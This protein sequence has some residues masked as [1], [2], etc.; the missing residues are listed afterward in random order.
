MPI[1]RP[2]RALRS[3]IAAPL[4]VAAGAVLG[5]AVLTASPAAADSPARERWPDGGQVHA[6][7]MYDG[8][9][10]QE[11]GCS[12][13]A[14]TVSQTSRD[15]MTFQLRWSSSCQ[16]NWVRILRYPGNI[17]AS[18]RDGLWMDVADLDREVFETFNGSTSLSG[19]RWG[20]MVYSPGAN[21]AR[22][23]LNYKDGS[24]PGWNFYD[25]VM[26]SSSC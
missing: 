9:D 11:T 26:Y 7:H 14:T 18:Q 21:C 8:A 23:A 2:R 25:V 4:A 22:G 13:G 15:G 5:A 1:P 6:Q 3:R 24:A 10:P 16:T 19:T 20:N 12:S 17:P